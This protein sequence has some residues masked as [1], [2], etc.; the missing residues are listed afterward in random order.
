MD[1][2]EFKTFL[3]HNT[4][5]LK[6]LE[7]AAERITR[8][9]LEEENIPFLDVTHRVKDLT[10][11][12]NKQRSKKYANPEME[13]TDLVGLRVI[14]YLESDIERAEVALRNCFEIDEANCVD[15]R[16]KSVD[17]VGYRSLHLV[18]SLGESRK[19]VPEYKNLFENKFEIQIRTAL[20]HTWAE[21]E[22]KQNYKGRN[23]LPENLQRRL[24]ILAGAL[25]LLDNEFSNIVSEA[26]VY[27]EMISEN[28]VRV[29][30]DEITV[31]SA[32]ALLVD[33]AKKYDREIE[34]VMAPKDRVIEELKNFGIRTNSELRKL[35]DETIEKISLVGEPFSLFGTYRDAM[36]TKDL[37][38]F[39]KD[40]YNGGF[41]FM[42]DEIDYLEG[43][44]GYE[45]VLDTLNFFGADFDPIYWHEV[46]E[47]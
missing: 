24:M 1:L 46:A 17:Q 22:H 28:N 21:I 6:K 36:M 12:E 34:P 15:K 7:E 39:L 16:K 5:K 13:M 23:I 27:G 40:A 8:H 9:A 37:D 2:H 14:V 47:P 42:R 19:E 25:E 41:T 11:A 3:S 38:R 31:T 45:N 26:Q 43:V 10:S 4:G 20:E 35:L 18:C 30:E 44:C 32:E 33:F 29:L